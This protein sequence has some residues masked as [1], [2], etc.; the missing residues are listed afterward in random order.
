MPLKVKTTITEEMIF[1]IFI[2]KKLQQTSLPA[3]P[4][5]NSKPFVAGK[6][7]AALASSASSLSNT[8]EPS[9]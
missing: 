2:L 7:I 6:D 8:G 5:P 4:L 3:K 9:P 1:R